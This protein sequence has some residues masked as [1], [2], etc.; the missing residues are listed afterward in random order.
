[1]LVDK[2]ACVC[3][4]V[5]ERERERGWKLNIES[6]ADLQTAFIASFSVV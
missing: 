4:C 1:M 3:V 2:L 5:R 6:G